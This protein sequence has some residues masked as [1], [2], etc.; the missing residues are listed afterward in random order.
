MTHD[1]GI[2]VLASLHDRG[3]L[4]P[5][6][7]SGMSIGQCVGWQMLIEN[8]ETRAGIPAR[9]GA[10]D[11]PA[12]AE[13]VMQVLRRG[14][15]D[16]PAAI[17]EAVYVPNHANVATHSSALA[18][19]RWPLICTTN[20]DDVYLRA[21][22]SKADVAH[23]RAVP[24][25]RG[26]SEQD[27]RSV[28]HHLSLPTDELLWCLQGFLTPD[29]VSVSAGSKSTPLNLRDCQEPGSDLNSEI[30]L[31][32]SEYRTVTHHAPHFRRCFAEVFRTRSF[33]FLG[34]G[35][36]ET[37]FRSLFDEVIELAGPSSHPHF[38]LVKKGALDRDF[39]LSHYDTILIEYELDKK[40]GHSKVAKFLD[41][42]AKA[43]AAERVR[44]QAWGWKVPKADSS[45]STSRPID[46]MTPDFSIVHA[47]LPL[48][49]SRLRSGDLVG[50]SCG[51]KQPK[52]GLYEPMPGRFTK[53]TLANELAKPVVR[54]DDYVVSWEGS[55]A[56]LRGIVARDP[57]K[58]NSRDA[59]SPKAVYIAFQRFLE[60]AQ[61]SACK[62]AFV[63]LL[64]SGAL[65]TFASWMSLVQMARA[66]GSWAKA[67]RAL[68]K[69]PLKVVVHLYRDD[70]VV[71]LMNGGYL[72]IAEPLEDAPMRLFI[73]T[74]DTT[75]RVQRRHALLNSGRKLKSIPP[76]RDSTTDP[77]LHALPVPRRGVKPSPLSE[78]AEATLS[79][80]GLVSGS[81][82]VADYRLA[83]IEKAR[84]AAEAERSHERPEID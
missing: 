77:A 57:N 6:I 78:V 83:S 33:L 56:W 79:D 31:S 16:V 62:V 11:L 47:P 3:L 40:N 58:K 34:S 48:D 37:Y 14:T 7:G 22:L 67:Q 75:G 2:K 66:Y 29:E 21:A 8:L 63:Q 54:R 61:R 60:D 10:H 50:I 51:R 17:R 65:K 74:V 64:S 76:F 18:Q 45:D 35:L 71:A 1:E 15:F 72:D 36:T 27:C 69:V 41:Q 12:R 46:D 5:F 30:V 4:V 20:Y 23:R 25:V 49:Q 39:M 82:L 84:L 73:E 59:R 28:L 81:T 68:G 32:H 13:S 43:T 80:L 24:K 70:E 53:Q 9:S 44:S 19:M 26:R 42:L 52:T 55:E 38:A